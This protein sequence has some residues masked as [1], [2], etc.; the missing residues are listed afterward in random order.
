MR[1]TAL[2]ALWLAQPL[3]G[4]TL[5]SCLPAD[6]IGTVPDDQNPPK[7]KQACLGYYD[8]KKAGDFYGGYIGP[9]MPPW[10]QPI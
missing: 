6:K 10:M 3:L 9:Y 4:L 2:A 1:R 5:C 7:T 8:W